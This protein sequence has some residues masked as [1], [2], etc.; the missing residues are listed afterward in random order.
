MFNTLLYTKRLEAVGLTREVAEAHVE[1]LAEVVETNLA[2]RD[3]LSVLAKELRHE[4]REM[5]SRLIIK[6]GAMMGAMFT[7]FF[8]L[9]KLF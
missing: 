2:T 5:E 4:M 7:I 3:D 8:A 6:M 9:I 1:L